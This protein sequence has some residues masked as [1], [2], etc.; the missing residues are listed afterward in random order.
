MLV[1][2]MDTIQH[3]F[4]QF[5]KICYVVNNFQFFSLLS[6]SVSCGVHNGWVALLL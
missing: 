4:I 5:N 1:V 3:L 6:Q 2:W